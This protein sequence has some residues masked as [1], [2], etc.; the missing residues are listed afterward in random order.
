MIDDTL[1]IYMQEPL[2]RRLRNTGIVL[3]LIGLLGIFLPQVISITLSLL[4]AVLLIFSGLSLAYLTWYSYNRSG[5]AWLKPFVL[6]SLGLLIAF[7]P[8]TGVAALGLM[9]IVYFLLDGFASISFAFALKPLPGWGWTLFSGIVSLILA[10][11]F[12]IDWP[13]SAMWLVGLF[14]GISLLFDGIALLMLARMAKG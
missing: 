1:E 4:I 11:V 3:S 9:L 2:R 12:I 13:F 14:V 10:I 8:I 6:V 5:L 7:Y